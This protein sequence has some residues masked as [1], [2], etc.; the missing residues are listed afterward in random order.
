MDKKLII[1]EIDKLKSAL[2]EGRFET[3]YLIYVMINNNTQPLEAYTELGDTAKNARVN[4][5]ILIHFISE[6]PSEP[7]PTKEEIIEEVTFEQ[8]IKELK[9]IWKK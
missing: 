8:Y 1:K 3:E 5:L 2:H 9:N 6:D 4:E 7:S